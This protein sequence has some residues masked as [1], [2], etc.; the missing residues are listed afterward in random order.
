MF[1]GNLAINRDQKYWQDRQ[2]MRD[3]LFL[4]RGLFLSI[5]L[6]QG[7]MTI[8]FHVRMSQ[9]TC[10]VSLINILAV[11]SSFWYNFIKIEASFCQS[12]CQR[13]SKGPIRRQVSHV[14]HEVVVA[15]NNFCKT[16]CVWWY[17][18]RAWPSQSGH[19]GSQPWHSGEVKIRTTRTLL[20]GTRLFFS[21]NMQ[22]IF[23]HILMQ[24]TYFWEAARILNGPVVA[25]NMLENVTTVKTVRN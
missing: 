2:N 14:S 11:L 23:H 21:K 5:A 25:H 10:F 12:R 9:K 22:N 16:L 19:K 24:F 4:S 20:I 15:H 18:Y 7:W 6:C 8:I 17:L 13:Q 1:S 3:F